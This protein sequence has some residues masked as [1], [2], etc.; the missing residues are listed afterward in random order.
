MRHLFAYPFIPPDTLISSNTLLYMKTLF[1][2]IFT[3]LRPHT[4][5]HTHK[6]LHTQCQKVYL[7]INAGLTQK[8]EYLFTELGI[9]ILFKGQP[10]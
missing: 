6:H 7:I 2:S 10:I 3:H 9:T 1:I 4:Y 5:T 8:Y